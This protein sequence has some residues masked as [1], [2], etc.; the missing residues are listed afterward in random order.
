MSHFLSNL[1]KT[2]PAK[3]VAKLRQGQAERAQAE[4]TSSSATK[5]DEVLVGGQRMLL[6]KVCGCCA[7]QVFVNRAAEPVCLAGLPADNHSCLCPCSNA[8][9]HGCR[10]FLGDGPLRALERGENG[11]SMLHR[12]LCTCVLLHAISS[13]P[14]TLAPHLVSCS[15]AHRWLSSMR[16]FKS[17]CEPQQTRSRG[18]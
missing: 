15:N 6:L 11:S 12:L 7:V 8:D 9:G 13:L 3:F 5:K 4:G 17:A 14:L 10:P 16:F 1:I 2:Q 18:A